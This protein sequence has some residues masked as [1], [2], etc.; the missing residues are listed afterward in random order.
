MHVG[1]KACVLLIVVA[2][3][4]SAVRLSFFP[5]GAEITIHKPFVSAARALS[6]S[7]PD[8][9][10]LP[11]HVQPP[12]V[13]INDFIII[14]AGSSTTESEFLRHTRRV[15]RS[16]CDMH[17]DKVVCIEA[18]PSLSSSAAAAAPETADSA[19]SA[20][21]TRSMC[22]EIHAVLR[23]PI[24]EKQ[25][26]SSSRVDVVV[27]G[28]GGGGGGGGRS[29]MRRVLWLG[30]GAVIMN[31]SLSIA[32]VM[33][34]SPHP[35][36]VGPDF[37]GTALLLRDGDDGA[38]GRAV[39]DLLARCGNGELKRSAACDASPAALTECMR[40][41]G[42]GVQIDPTFSAPFSS[43]GKRSER[44]AEEEKRRRKHHFERQQRNPFLVSFRHC[45]P[46]HELE[47]NSLLVAQCLEQ[48][49][50]AVEQSARRNG[51]YHQLPDS[52]KKVARLNSAVAEVP[53]TSAA[54]IASA[55]TPAPPA[56]LFPTRT[57]FSSS[58]SAASGPGGD[59][60]MNPAGNFPKIAILTIAEYPETKKNQRVS[61]QH[62]HAL[63]AHFIKYG[64]PNKRRYC[65][66]WGY[67]FI[68][69][70]AAALDPKGGR[71]PAY[72]K[73][74]AVLKW[75]P[76]YD[77]ILWMDAD[78][79]FMN[80]NLTI[81]AHVLER[82]AVERRATLEKAGKNTSYV[83]QDGARVLPENYDFIIARD[84]NGIN[85]GVFVVRNSE[86]SIGFFKRVEHIGPGTRECDGIPAD[87]WDQ[88]NIICLLERGK[89]RA[90]DLS[91]TR[92][93]N[94]QRRFNSYGAPTA[95]GNQGAM[96]REGDFIVHFPNMKSFGGEGYEA[97]R[98]H[99]TLSLKLNGLPPELTEPHE[100]PRTH[101][102]DGE[103]ANSAPSSVSRV[104]AK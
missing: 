9:P 27:G 85:S 8:T 4:L 63:T 34:L 98:S 64:Y 73:S 47:Q 32:D 23:S 61:M 36:L 5:S 78:T 70:S 46:P 104:S 7:A 43:S 37:A 26:A 57:S 91:H 10:S 96:F 100:P 2:L 87:W 79:L 38:D 75:L 25:K 24:A 92:Q 20:A 21:A 28:S 90:E 54:P 68:L 66:K 83:S 101:Y 69:E 52:E 60:N 42:V 12:P 48:M 102:P 1:C 80:Y 35:L 14:A 81:E 45:S 3:S 44:D 55:T 99:Y 62:T 77:Y 13:K 71:H 29:V 51:W 82:A 95:M 16:Y 40:P 50:E 6:V 15:A 93:Y 56:D 76:R 94:D 89:H 65:E 49:A 17:R 22:R 58:A 31:F 59:G 33:H 41:A 19:T 18:A 67:D 88:R 97:F 86:W 72:A 53:V 30:P 103:S 84:W 11:F 74:R 39:R